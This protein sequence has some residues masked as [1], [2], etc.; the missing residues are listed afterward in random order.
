MALE[1][2]KLETIVVIRQLIWV[3]LDGMQAGEED[4]QR[5][6]SNSRLVGEVPKAPEGRCCWIDIGSEILFEESEVFNWLQFSL[7]R[8]VMY[9][10]D[11]FMF[12]H[13]FKIPMHVATLTP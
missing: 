5:S 1:G 12:S 8:Y 10:L 13:M 7:E 4:Q 2:W 11:V 6:D 9:L 3:M